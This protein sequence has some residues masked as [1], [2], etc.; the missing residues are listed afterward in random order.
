MDSNDFFRLFG[1]FGE[2]KFGFGFLLMA[3]R[4]K[5]VQTPYITRTN[6]YIGM[7]TLGLFWNPGFCPTRIKPVQTPYITRTN[8]YTIYGFRD[9]SDYLVLD[10]SFD[11]WNSWFLKAAGFP[12]AF[13]M[14]L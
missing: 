10:G 9:V 5:P 4:I 13:A 1:V 8:P 11:N 6:P 7:E 2:K 3:T 14:K 12:A